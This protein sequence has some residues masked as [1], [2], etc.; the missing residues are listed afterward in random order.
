MES[1]KN[2]NKK[3]KDTI[4]GVFTI[5]GLAINPFYFVWEN[6]MKKKVLMVL[7]PSRIWLYVSILHRED[8][9]WKVHTSFK[10]KNLIQKGTHDGVFTNPGLTINSL[11]FV[12]R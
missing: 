1:S 11:G 12:R 4:G 2:I 7:L 8:F 10:I 3:E 5:L 6:S 9:F